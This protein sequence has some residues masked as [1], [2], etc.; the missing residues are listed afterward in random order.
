MFDNQ[1]EFSSTTFTKKRLL[2]MR[3]R[4]RRKRE[5]E[6]KVEEEYTSLNTI[7]QSFLFQF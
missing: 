1:L 2:T 4:R 5:K 6:E 7:S 3:S